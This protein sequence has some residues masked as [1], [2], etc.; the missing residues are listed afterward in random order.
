MKVGNAQYATVIAQNRK[1]RAPRDILG[2]LFFL[3]LVTGDSNGVIVLYSELNRLL[4]RDMAG[5]GPVFLRS[6][7]LCEYH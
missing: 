5:P 7:G 4:E 1:I 6:H 3:D 2:V